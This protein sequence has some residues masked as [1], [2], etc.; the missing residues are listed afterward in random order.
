MKTIRLLCILGCR[1]HAHLRCALS[2]VSPT[3]E[4]LFLIIITSF[5]KVTLRRRDGRVRLE[6][7]IQNGDLASEKGNE[8]KKQH[9][10]RKRNEPCLLNF[11]AFTIVYTCRHLTESV[12]QEAFS[13]VIYLELNHSIISNGKFV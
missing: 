12:F 5:G 10:R 1:D 7:A 13:H 8:R 6:Q 2:S 9:L 3:R 4:T 11:V